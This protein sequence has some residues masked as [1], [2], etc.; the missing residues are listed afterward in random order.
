MASICAPG[1]DANMDLLDTAI[2]IIGAAADEQ[3]GLTSGL[4]VDSVDS[5]LIELGLELFESV[6]DGLDDAGVDWVDVYPDILVDAVRLGVDHEV[7]SRILEN[8]ADV[9]S[10]E[11]VLRCAIRR[12]DVNHVLLLVAQSDV[13]KAANDWFT[14][15]PEAV[16]EEVAGVTSTS[17]SDR[18]RLLEA[19]VY[20][21]EHLVVIPETNGRIGIFCALSGRSYECTCTCPCEEEILTTVLS[22]ICVGKI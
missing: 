18:A 6:V 10:L 5:A 17:R 9:P 16:L 21:R 12:R 15:C 13:P 1:E 8:L 4:G 3:E 11:A 19:L 14:E 22:G 20:G 2:R 7:L